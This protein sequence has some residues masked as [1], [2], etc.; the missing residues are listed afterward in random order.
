M[1]VQERG[2]LR[3]LL[4]D[5]VAAFY[6]VD[7]SVRVPQGGRAD[8]APTLQAVHSAAASHLAQVGRQARWHFLS[9]RVVVL[10]GITCAC[11]CSQYEDDRSRMCFLADA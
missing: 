11:D 10:H 9:C 6:W 5:N 7:R 8:S 4:L 3:L 1:H 2:G